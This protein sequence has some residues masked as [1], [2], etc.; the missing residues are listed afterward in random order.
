MTVPVAKIANRP[1]A[2]VHR[3]NVVAICPIM[4]ADSSTGGRLGHVA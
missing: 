3:E 2:Q 1:A 4:A